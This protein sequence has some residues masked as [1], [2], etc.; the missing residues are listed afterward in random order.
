[1]S[2]Y[3]RFYEQYYELPPGVGRINLL[4]EGVRLAD[5][6]ND[7][8]EAYGMRRQLTSDAI[9]EGFPEKGIV[10]FSWCMAQYDNDQEL[11]DW[12]DILWQYKTI[13]E[14]IPIFAT[15]SRDQIISMQE[16]MARRLA[17]VGES[18]RTAHYYRAWNFMR[19][20]DYQ[21]ALNHQETYMAM[22]RTQISD[23]NACEL[24][25]QVELLTRMHQDEA[26]LKLA[27]PV[28]SGKMICGEVPHFTNGHVVKS[29]LRLGQLK[30]ATATLA[31]GLEIVQGERKYL[32]TIGDLLLVIVRTRDFDQGLP[33]IARNL[34]AA[35]ECAAG[36]L[37]FRFFS[38][39]G[40]FFE[41][42]AVASPQALKLK[43]PQSMDCFVE[44]SEYLPAELSVWFAAETLKLAGQF[45]SRNGNEAYTQMIKEHR[46]L[47]G[48]G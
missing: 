8:A 41:A 2:D 10:A 11:D 15:V 19:M 47:C 48:L 32:G 43:I 6:N 34:K 1:M 21:T 22:Q 30:K 20:G 17:T 12:H 36:E 25:R 23:C 16:D 13:L 5:S 44:N 35:T 4:E 18:E 46:E 3:D 39:A 37:K 45:N 33:Q 27:A 40:L 28:I 7:I 24:D 9:H 29:Q 31:S 38:S 14:L 26:A 42:L